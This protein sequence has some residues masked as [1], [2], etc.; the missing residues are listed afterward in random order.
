MVHATPVAP[1]LASP[2]LPPHARASAGDWYDP[3][4]S[5]REPPPWKRFRLGMLRQAVLKPWFNTA[6]LVVII[7]NCVTLALNNPL[8]DE[9]SSKAKVLARVDVVFMVLFS[10]EMV[11]KWVAL[12]F[13]S[14]GY[15]RR[16]L[17]PEVVLDD[18]NDANDADGAG[19]ASD[20]DDATTQHAARD[21]VSGN[22]GRGNSTADEAAVGIEMPVRRPVALGTSDSADVGSGSDV[23]A[24]DVPRQF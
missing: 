6:V 17:M 15:A 10:V 12:G 1:R 18:V 20:A 3:P 16:T 9:N 14:R 22:R 2:H 8:D 7:A 13:C 19:D 21:V 24:R 5:F 11:M 4:R 23:Q